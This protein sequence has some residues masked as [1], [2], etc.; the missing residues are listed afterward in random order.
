M[1]IILITAVIVLLIFNKLKLPTMIG[2]FIT[3]IVLGHVVN[4]TS[5]IST[6]SELGVIF[7]LFIIG[8][9]FSAEKFTAIK[10]YALIGGILQV[11]I[12]TI[13]VT[14]LGFALNL[15]WN[16]ALFLGFLVAFSSTAI[17]MKVMQQRHI[18]HSVQGRV[19][20]GIL[21]FQDIAVIIVILLTPIL[22]G[23]SVETHLL[24][25]LIVKALGLGLIIFAGAKW[26]IPLALRDAARTKNRDLFLLLTLFICMGT[27]FAT[28]LIGI[29][30]ELGAFIAGL[31]ISNTEYS[32]QT[33]GYIQ[34][35]QD[36]FMSLFFISIGL[37]VN[38]HLFLS[39]IGIIILLT[40]IIVIINFTATFITGMA[41]KLPTKI[42][43]SIAILL[44]QI[45]EFSF[46]L[47][48]EGMSYGLMTNEFF[49][50]FL[51]V[52]ILT[53]SLTPFLEKATPQIVKLIGKISYFQVDD[54]LKTL[55]EELEE[56][57]KIEGHVILVG[58]GRN[59]KH[60][61]KAC[62]QF[63]IPIR[64]VDMNPTI[65]ENQQALGLPI[66][67]GRA[68]NESV[69]KELNITSA[70]CIVISASTYE[71]TM[72]TIDVARRLNPDIH[73]IV[74]TRYL[75]SIDDVIEAGADE[76]IPKEFETS[77]MMF[78]RIMDYYNKDVD[79]ITGAVNDLRSNNYDA[80]R[81]VTSEDITTY[82]NYK[83]T[84]LE[85]DSLRVSE[86]A[87]IDDF[88]FEENNLK[89]TGV[90][91]GEDTFIDVK[92]D[93]KFFEDDLILFIGHREN[94]NK[95]FDTI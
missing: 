14:L 85:I 72:K 53:M 81:T 52:S 23:E 46:V 30:P 3:G 20:L 27:T 56:E 90:V 39:N 65:V 66:I 73:I 60:I 86:N 29:G 42:S 33:L 91:R 55:P 12:T 57:T 17:V 70:Q 67:Y 89:V 6:L 93:F 44:S 9:E 10:H 59:G 75:K 40:L 19:T 38:L 35:F 48:K 4:D 25:Q 82:L 43:V 45:G 94:I 11:I 61:A 74:R 50:I 8:L 63:R 68:S 62:R 83:Y 78:T 16:S 80:F 36:V 71:E 32:H 7:L 28:S 22:G 51:G 87:H 21:I 58:L 15:S 84:D 26:F 69:L 24:P 5:I 54:E 76:V 79:E 18:T 41:L 49:S 1:S 64:I 95:F 13:L 88:P 92:S 47:A 34:P 37:M 31:L 77:I 2:L